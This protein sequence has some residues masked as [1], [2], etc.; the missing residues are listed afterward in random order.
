VKHCPL[1][2]CAGTR[3]RSLILSV[4]LR[5]TASDRFEKRRRLP[6][7]GSDGLG[8][9]ERRKRRRP[10][11]C[12]SDS[13]LVPSRCSAFAGTR[14]INAGLQSS[15]RTVVRDRFCASASRP[16]RRSSSF[17]RA[18]R[19]RTLHSIA[20]SLTRPLIDR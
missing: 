17:F 2:R 6:F 10:T 3:S 5:P 14:A 7:V 19:C 13:L 18:I 4:R 11:D 20:R 1:D 8:F 9:G 12:Q 16:H 15:K